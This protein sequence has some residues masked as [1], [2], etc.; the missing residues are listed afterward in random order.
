MDV[1]T[2]N[3]KIEENNTLSF[4]DIFSN[5]IELFKKVWLQGFIT[6][7]LTTVCMLPFYLMIY[8]PMVVMGIADPEMMQQEEPPAM[9][10]LAMILIM[11]IVIMAAMV[12]SIAFMAAFF[13]ICR[14]KDLGQDSADDYFYYFKNG[15]LKKVLSLALISL[16]LS[17]LGALA[18]GIGM[19]YVIVPVSLI[20]AFLAFNT[21][22]SPM[23]MV[24]ASFK[25]GNKNWLIIFGL[26]LIM[27]L[28]A[29]LGVLLCFVG[30]LF[31][32]MLAKIPVYYIY[33]DGVGFSNED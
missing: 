15:N 32:A 9:F 24:K 26:I 6:V 27:G 14:Q 25:L 30:L 5:S 18:C 22:L 8:I 17:L 20:P 33:K 13:R 4:G 23:E 31:T 21:E 19:I 28:L 16:G 2:L 11:P 1:N 3:K 10:V 29:E 12:I 7:L